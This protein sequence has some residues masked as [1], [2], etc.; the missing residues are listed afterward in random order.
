[1]IKVVRENGWINFNRGDARALEF[2]A[3]ASR[4]RGSVRDECVQVSRGKISVR[5][6]AVAAVHECAREFGVDMS[7]FLESIGVFQAHEKARA[8]AMKIVADKDDSG[9][10]GELGF[11]KSHQKV[12]VN[13]MTQKGLLG[14]CLFDEQGTG[15]TLT[16]LAA[17]YSLKKSGQADVMM[18]VAPSSV[19][20]AWRSDVKREEFAEF[21]VSVVAGSREEKEK[22]LRDCA[23]IVLMSYDTLTSMLSTAKAVAKR[24]SK[25]LLVADEAF[26]IKNSDARRSRAV[27]EL[28]DECVRAFVLS[29][30]PAPRSA[31]DVIHQSDIADNGYAFQG[32]IPEGDA[33]ADADVIYDLLSARGAFLRQPK[34]EVLTLP[35]KE[36][37]IVEVALSGEQLLAYRSARDDLALYLLGINNE[38]LKK[39][40]V[41]Y[42]QR[43]ATLLQLCGCPSMAVGGE[44]APRDHAKLLKLDDLINNVVVEGGRKIVVWTSYTKSIHELARRY[45]HHGLVKIYGGSSE[46][47]REEAI[48]LFQEDSA[49][50]IFLG[51]PAAAGA[52]IT[53]H[54]AA[55][56]VYVSYSDK[57]AEFI[58][59]IDRT[60]RIGQAADSVRYHFLVCENTVEVNQVRLLKQKMLNQ[61]LMFG[62][63]PKWPSTVDDALDELGEGDD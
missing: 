3:F 43:R 8:K 33:V 37:N 24:V 44:N 41:N 7:E 39:E 25:C 46:K 58:Q 32:F 54:A 30:T 20:N 16:T 27:R 45:N 56:S 40:L 4:V 35:P 15:K 12:A 49:V 18:V 62:E 61:H 14:L 50:K 19:I 6:S 21:S 10:P 13:A 48:R 52:G 17:F 22:A 31:E 23:D 38:T 55:D 51:N 42:F 47:E 34:S 29:G 36:F 2:A 26:L 57:A 59:S 5:E 11:L 1:M 28:R 63:D 53:L 9:I 60:H